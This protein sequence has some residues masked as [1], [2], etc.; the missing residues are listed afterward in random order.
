MPRF[1]SLW[2]GREKK[3]SWGKV[4]EDKIGEKDA[5]LSLLLTQGGEEGA[6]ICQASTQHLLLHLFN[7]S[8]RVGG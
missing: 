1:A 4:V 6:N 2:W 3:A 5:E 7:S 8:H